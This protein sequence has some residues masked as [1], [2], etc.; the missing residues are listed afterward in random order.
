VIEFLGDTA[1]E[2]ILGKDKV[3]EKPEKRDVVVNINPEGKHAEDVNVGNMNNGVDENNAK[4][5]SRQSI[6]TPMGE[7]VIE[8]F[9]DTAFENALDKDPGKDKVHKKPEKRDMVVNINPEGK[10]DE[11]VNLGILLSRTLSI[12]IPTKTRFTRSL[13]RGTL[14]LTS[15][16]RA[17]TRTWTWTTWWTTKPRKRWVKHQ[18]F[19]V[20]VMYS[21]EGDKATATYRVLKESKRGTFFSKSLF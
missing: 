4:K 7:P 2:N 12:R 3:H 20:S 1:F 6:R 9:G 11:D 13:R 5:L 10:Y 16:P 19:L 21:K 8:F 14:W 17:S 18:G 15:T